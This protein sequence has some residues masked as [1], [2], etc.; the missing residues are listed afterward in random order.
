MGVGIFGVFVGSSVAVQLQVCGLRFLLVAL[1]RRSLGLLICRFRLYDGHRLSRPLTLDSALDVER[2]R[3]ALVTR[4]REVFAIGLFDVVGVEALDVLPG[5]ACLAVDRV[6]VIVRE[7][8]NT[9]DGVGLF[10]NRRLHLLGY[11]LKWDGLAWRGDILTGSRDLRRQRREL[12]CHN[13]IEA[14][15][16]G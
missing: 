1:G 9:L 14:S 3:L 11:I 4:V 6:S 13:L 8:A 15:R 12:F 7:V 2:P 16:R 10:L 5:I